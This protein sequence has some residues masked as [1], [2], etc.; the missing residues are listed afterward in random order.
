MVTTNRDS[1]GHRFTEFAMSDNEHVRVTYVP[2]ADWA[3]GPTLRVQKRAYT[4][5]MS[6][7]PEFPARCAPELLAAVAQLLLQRTEP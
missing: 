1:A 6:P 2:Y 4:G 3:K 7:G 5:R